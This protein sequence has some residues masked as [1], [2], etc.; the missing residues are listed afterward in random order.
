MMKKLIQ[1]WLGIDKL[2]HNAEV[3]IEL[4]DEIKED[5]REKTVYSFEKQPLVNI[6]VKDMVDDNAHKCRLGN[7]EL[8]N[9]I[10]RLEKL[11]N[12]STKEK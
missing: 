7:S 5:I 8:Y 2:Y 1:K 9:E 10:K 6:P 11:I 3:I 4:R 12:K